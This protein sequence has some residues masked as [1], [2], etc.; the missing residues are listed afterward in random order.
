MFGNDHEDQVEE[1]DNIPAQNKAQDRRNDFPL[2]KSC[3]KAAD[4]CRNGNDCE[5]HADEVT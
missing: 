5:D 1:P 2:H 3:D 4:K